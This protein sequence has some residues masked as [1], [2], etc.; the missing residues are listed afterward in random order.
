MTL[1]PRQ[2][3]TLHHCMLIGLIQA[4]YRTGQLTEEQFHSLMSDEKLWH[5]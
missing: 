4:L 3:N 1:T 2:E 5:I